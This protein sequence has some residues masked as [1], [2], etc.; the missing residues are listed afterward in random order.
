MEK[1]KKF[2]DKALRKSVFKR[3]CFF[4]IFDTLLISGA[5]YFAFWCRFNGD[6]PK[7]YQDVLPL[8]IF[9]ALAVKLTFLVIYNLYDIS[10]RYVSLDILVKVF[11]AISLGSLSLG[12]LL[13]MTRLFLI[14][15]YAAM[16]R[17]VL[18]MDYMFS[19]LFIG[20][21]RVAKR[22]YYDGL[23]GAVKNRDE[24]RKVLIVGAGSAGE[25]IVRDMK[26]KRDPKFIPL[27]FVDDDP[28]KKNITIHGI[29]V[30]GKHEDIPQII[31]NNQIDEVLIAIPSAESKEI[32]AIVDSVREVKAMSDIKI[33]PG[34]SDLVNGRVSL[35][36]VK[37][38]R[39]EDLLGREPVKIDYKAIKDFIEGQTVLVSGAGGSIGSEVVKTVSRFHPNLLIAFDNDETELFYLENRIKNID[40]QVIYTV[41]DIKD[42]N[43]VSEI[44]DA[45][46]PNI[47][48]HAAAYKHVP[49]LETHLNEAVKT[50]VLGTK[51]LAEQSIKNGVEKFVFIST[52]KAINPTSVMGATKRCSEELLRALNSENGTEF[53]SVRFGNVLGSRG[54]VI[55]VFK[56]QIKRGG[57][58][59]VTHPD[60]KRYFMSTKEAVLL[61]LEAASFGKGGEVFILDMGEPIKIKDLAREMIR[62]SGYEPDVDIPIVFTESRPGEKLHEEVL[63]AEEGT[64]STDYEKIF[65]AKN[66][67]EIDSKK[68][69]KRVNQFSR[70]CVDGNN[71]KK[72]LKLMKD[73]VPTFDHKGDL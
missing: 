52:D 24:K 4:F 39:L 63:G 41:G 19:L 65:I 11:K 35:S 46:N 10:W 56:R 21:L 23:R 53:V 22:V 58:V 30:L 2:F 72:I 61:T 9:L 31:K 42:L 47:V 45:Y 68:I 6:I 57:P 54:S 67:N 62:L 15:Q 70:L 20:A 3:R 14:F 16:P 28:S 5:M 43:R 59:T 29:R 38:V 64:E 69:F 44:F 34:T 26:R 51:V 17:A 40:S 60:M 71:H 32:K 66:T 73:I 36:D 25:Q 48:I 7:Q 33:L 49:L 27:G 50:N 12:L 18:L 13:Y 1:M 8:Y 55:P 37:K